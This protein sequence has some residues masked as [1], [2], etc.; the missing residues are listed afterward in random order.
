MAFAM[1]CHA[2]PANDRLGLD[3]PDPTRPGSIAALK[4][5]VRRLE[6]GRALDASRTVPLGVAAID[7]LLPGGGLAQAR[8]HEVVGDGSERDGAAAGFTLLLIARLMRRVPGRVLGGG[9]HLDLN[10]P[11]L[12]RLGIDTPRLI[13][14]RARETTD[15]L[16][17]MEEGLRTAGLAAVAGE[18][19][20]PIDLT[21][22]RRLQLAAEAG[23]ATG[24]SLP[25][26]RPG[27]GTPSA[28][29]ARWRAH[30]RRWRA[31]AR[32]GGAR[33]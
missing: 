30:P 14:V 1:P 4:A 8:V 19:T 27:A 9:R 15:T 13:L 10:G 7:R 29:E 18:L 5:R 31:C 24:L 26:A 3:R 22:S 23:G 2:E 16:W 25:P 28:V 20:R 32:C 17:A 11:G 33:P 6:K 21:Q 12:A